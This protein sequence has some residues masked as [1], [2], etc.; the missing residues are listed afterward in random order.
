MFK[1]I[2][3][4]IHRI[5]GTLLSILFL[6]WFLSGFVMIYHTFPKVQ[7]QDK[8]RTMSELDIKDISPDTILSFIPEEE[9]ITHIQLHKPAGQPVF[10]IRTDKQ[11]YQISAINP[12]AAV[13]SISFDEIRIY[14]QQW[15]IAPIE[16]VDTL[17]QLEQ[18][19]PFSR[20]REDMPIYKFYFSDNLQH[21]LYVS[22]VTGEAIQFT[23][24]ESRFWS[25]LGAIPHWIYFTGLRQDA[26]LW[27]DL[28]IWLSGI[29]CIMCL[30]GTILGIR[31]YYRIYRKKKQFRSPYKKTAYKWHHI[32]GFFFG[33]FV[34]TFA[35]S[36]M[37]SLAQVPQ[38][39]SK[40]HNKDIQ[41]QLL[42]KGQT[43]PL[44]QY[45]TDIHTIRKHYPS[46][47]KSV[48]W[49]SFGH[50]PIYKIIVEDTMLFVNATDTYIRPL[51][52]S[53][54]NVNDYI[55]NIHT[56]N[57]IFTLLN[58]YD[59]Y[60][61]ARKSELPLPVYKVCIDDPDKSIYYINPRTGD[62]RYFNANTRIRKWTYQGLHSFSFKWL[63]DRPVLWNIL[64][65]TTMIGGTI[66]SLTG[67]W[68]GI[69][70]IKRLIKRRK[71]PSNLPRRE[72]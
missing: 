17:Y 32:L 1:R 57:K 2:I 16:R 47:I 68:L 69:K 18:W 56:E 64:M 55:S 45:R 63:A 62:I 34:F 28:I 49:T 10:K 41:K 23:D 7:L 60:Y 52:L 42:Q 40:Q 14:A 37:M 50:I 46:G 59:D 27:S 30:S 15:N 58:E 65:W 48:E 13:G 25:W 5:L 4:T 70:Y 67:V 12:A 24:K 72:A 61:I 33:L 51:L 22:S 9:T 29:G 43:L 11:T 31:S 19:I 44:A 21:Q 20:Y 8:Y 54:Q 71:G 53:E 36:G 3:Y 38:W 66:V 39:I 6:V 35:F 26:R